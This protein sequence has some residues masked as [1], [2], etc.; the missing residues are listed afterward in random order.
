MDVFDAL[1]DGRLDEL[2]A[3]L[4]AEPQLAAERHSSGASL[5]AWA[6]YTGKREAAPIIRPHLE[7]LDAWDAIIAG[8]TAAVELAIADGWD[9]NA[10]APDGF[11][12]LGLAA[13]F[14]H[15][16]LFALLL[17]LTRDVNARANNRQQVAALHAA[18]TNRDAAM[19]EALLQAGADPNLTQAAGFTPLHAAAHHGDAAIVALLLGAGA[20]PLSSNDKGQTPVEL[21]RA[22]GHEHIA[23]SLA[24]GR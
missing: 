5:F 20:D 19:V 14:G 4:A 16:D 8:D 18:T 17:P 22:A 7:P 10:P 24:T 11:T 3:A 12:P 9:P 6:H 1:A 2:A 13:F 23:S 21:A 15:A